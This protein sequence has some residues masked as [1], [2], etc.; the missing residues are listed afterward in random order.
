MI[1]ST[2]PAFLNHFRN[3]ASL[4]IRQLKIRL[5]FTSFRVLYGALVVLCEIY[6]LVFVFLPQVNVNGLK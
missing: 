4:E 1:D 5:V 2:I 6:D 3:K